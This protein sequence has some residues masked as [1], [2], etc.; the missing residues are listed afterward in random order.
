MKDQ[1]EKGLLLHLWQASAHLFE[2]LID[3]NVRVCFQVGEIELTQLAA[4]LHQIL[5]Y[6]G[7]DVPMNYF[8]DQAS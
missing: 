8:N 7:L 1:L 5:Q 4:N 2:Y 6:D 3:I